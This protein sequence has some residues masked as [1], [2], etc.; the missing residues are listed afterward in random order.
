MKQGATEKLQRQPLFLQS[1]KYF[2]A[3]ERQLDVD[4][5]DT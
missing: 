4:A 3:T 5:A 1:L 2:A